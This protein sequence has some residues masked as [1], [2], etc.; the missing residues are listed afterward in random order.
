MASVT[1]TSLRKLAEAL[2]ANHG[3]L[4]RLRRNPDWPVSP[5]A[6]W[7]SER[8]VP[9]IRQWMARRSE[10]RFVPAV[11]AGG[12]GVGQNLSPQQVAQIKLYMARER[13]I[14]LRTEIRRGEYIRRDEVDQGRVA[15]ILA[16]K[17]QLLHMHRRLE[18]RLRAIIKREKTIAKV[19]RLIDDE[20]KRVLDTFSG[21][22]RDGDD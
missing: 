5:T 21:G 22:R 15:R 6:P 18:E 13:D 20:A 16:V 11:A 19:L 10:S 3:V 1:I 14:T 4:S 9:A 7:D 8:D 17:D 2:G 12:R